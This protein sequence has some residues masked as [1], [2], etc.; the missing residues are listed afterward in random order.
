MLLVD[1]LID[2]LFGWLMDYVPRVSIFHLIFFQVRLWTCSFA[3]CMA[4]VWPKWKA[5]RRNASWPLRG[6]TRWMDCFAPVKT[7]WSARWTRTMLDAFWSLRIST[8][9]WIW[10]K[11]RSFISHVIWRNSSGSG[12]GRNWPITGRVC[13]KS[14]RRSVGWWMDDE[15][16]TRWPGVPK[17][18]QWSHATALCPYVFSQRKFFFISG[19]LLLVYI[20]YI[21]F[22]FCF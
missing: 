22:S 5:V 14:W 7:T 6:S 13:R 15:G 16:V 19:C 20:R 9:R 8:R 11:S 4:A 2:W 17:V 18:D 12:E 10:N 1:W 21:F 3:T